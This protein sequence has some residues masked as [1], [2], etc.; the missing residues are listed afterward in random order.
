MK[1]KISMI[2][3]KYVKRIIDILLA[4]IG[5]IVLSPIFLILAIVI[6]YTSKGPVLF[7]QIRVGK[8][9]KPFKILKF[10]SMYVETPKDMPTH[11][12]ENPDAFITNVGRIMR[13]TSLD[14]LPQL[15]NILVGDMSI[16]GPR[17]SL[18]NQLDL[19]DLRDKNGA[20]SIRPGLTGLAQVSGRDELE[21]EAK[22]GFDGQYANEITL[23]KDTSLFLKT[24]FSVFTSDGVKEGKM[25]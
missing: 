2:Y 6:K 13:K 18:P 9:N 22:A 15:W 7:K 8:D 3:K 12:L 19:N 16:I 21:I 25:Q 20:S 5:I 23:L 11:M 14:E 4:F 24:I 10:R 1:G 17:P